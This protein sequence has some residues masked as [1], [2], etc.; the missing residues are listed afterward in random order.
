MKHFG[1]FCSL[2][3]LCHNL[4][5]CSAKSKEQAYKALVRLIAEYSATVWDPYV[6]KNIQQVKMIQRWAARWVRGRYHRLDSVTNMLCSLKWKSLELRRSDTR[7][8]MLYKQSNGLAT[9]EC[10]KLQQEHKS[11][12]DTRISSLSHMATAIATCWIPTTATFVNQ[13]MLAFLYVFVHSRSIGIWMV[14]WWFLRE[15]QSGT[16]GSRKTSPIKFATCVT[17]RALSPVPLLY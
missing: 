10:D 9:Y 11:R 4:R 6:A 15:A 14:K 17:A 2:F 5:T 7:L 12:M 1:T 16:S 8:Y 13:Q 3:F